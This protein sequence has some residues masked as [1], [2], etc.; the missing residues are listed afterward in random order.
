MFFGFG[1]A[2]TTRTLFVFVSILTDGSN[3]LAGSCNIQPLEVVWCYACL[4]LQ[5]RQHLAAVYRARSVI[6]PGGSSLPSDVSGGLFTSP[7]IGSK[8]SRQKFLAGEIPRIVG[9]AML[10]EDGAQFLLKTEFAMMLALIPNVAD[11]H[12]EI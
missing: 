7:R 3:T 5:V 4:P 12:V 10:L 1:G 8:S 6:V 2:P 11:H 9:D